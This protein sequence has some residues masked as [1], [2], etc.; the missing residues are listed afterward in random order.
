MSSV[1]LAFCLLLPDFSVYIL[2]FPIDV[3]AR[4]VER[5]ALKLN[6]INGGVS[7]SSS[8][9]LGPEPPSELPG[10]PSTP[11]PSS[12]VADTNAHGTQI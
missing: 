11:P 9:T 4:L 2:L 7:A 1:P 3:Y 10:S 5:V 6:P 12:L 8:L